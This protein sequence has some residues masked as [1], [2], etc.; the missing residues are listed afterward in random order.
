M[1]FDALRVKI[2]D[3]RLVHKAVDLALAITSEGDNE[4]LRLWIEQTKRADERTPRLAGC[5]T[6]SSR[7][8]TR[9]RAFPPPSAWCS[10]ASR[11]RVHLNSAPVLS[12]KPGPPHSSFTDP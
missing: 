10:R 4:V 8:W 7:R 1:S 3:E 11:S 5:R 12:D 2:R 9:S 6:S